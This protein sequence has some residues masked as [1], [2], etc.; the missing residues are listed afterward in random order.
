M[1]SAAATLRRQGQGFRAVSR[2]G[3]RKPR[4][5]VAAVAAGNQGCAPQPEPASFAAAEQSMKSP[6]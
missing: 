5:A 1:A 3:F 2:A 4:V 6:G